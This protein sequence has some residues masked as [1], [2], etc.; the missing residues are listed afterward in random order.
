MK[1]VVMLIVQAIRTADLFG[2][3]LDIYILYKRNHV[4]K[5]NYTN[6]QLIFRAVIIILNGLL[7]ICIILRKLFINCIVWLQNHF[8]S[9]YRFLYWYCC[10]LIHLSMVLAYI[11]ELGLSIYRTT[12]VIKSN[13][14]DK[15]TVYGQNETQINKN[16]Q[17]YWFTNDIIID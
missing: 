5:S 4:I 13:I 8:K 11:N 9:H 12:E 2:Y 7:D 17:S 15:T 3:C 10:G 1:Y 6:I 16:I 14:K